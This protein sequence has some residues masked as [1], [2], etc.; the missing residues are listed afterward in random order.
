[1]HGLERKYM[2]IRRS[3]GPRKAVWMTYKA[4]RAVV[5]KRRVFARH[6]ESRISRTGDVRR[7]TGMR[8]ER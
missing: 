2:P 1:M 5:N 4:R 6:E 7:P 8:L 3:G